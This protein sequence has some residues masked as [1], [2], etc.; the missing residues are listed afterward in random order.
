MSARF[1][2]ARNEAALELIKRHKGEIHTPAGPKRN[3][4][5]RKTHTL[6]PRPEA[7]VKNDVAPPDARQNWPP[8]T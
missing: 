2:V 1:E 8:P 6:R 5:L 4:C 3:G 7:E